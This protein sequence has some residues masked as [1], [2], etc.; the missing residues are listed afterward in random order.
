MKS[1]TLTVAAAAMVFLFNPRKR[2]S[3]TMVIGIIIP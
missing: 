3:I 2:G 1:T